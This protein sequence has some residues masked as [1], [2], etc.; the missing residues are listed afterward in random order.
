MLVGIGV[1]YSMRIRKSCS[2]SKALIAFYKYFAHVQSVRL[3]ML[4]LFLSYVTYMSS[5]QLIFC[6]AEHSFRYYYLY[7]MFVALLYK[8]N[9]RYFKKKRVYHDKRTSEPLQNKKISLND[10]YISYV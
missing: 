4:D 5:Y 6:V 1:R 3:C 10:W 9:N 2:N 7:F 8:Y